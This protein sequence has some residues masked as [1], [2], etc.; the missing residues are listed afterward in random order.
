MGKIPQS[1]GNL[2][3]FQSLNFSNNDL[4]GPVHPSMGVLSRPESLDLSQNKLS[5]STTTFHLESL[6]MLILSLIQKLIHSSANLSAE[7]PS[8][9]ANLTQLQHI[10]LAKNHLAG[11]ILSVSAKNIGVNHGDGEWR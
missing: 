1:I 10:D 9:L 6:L 7:I 3:G 11:K 5:G 4:V 2:K 8:S